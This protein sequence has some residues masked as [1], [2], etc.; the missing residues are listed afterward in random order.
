MELLLHSDL[1]NIPVGDLLSMYFKEAAKEPLLKR[2]EEI[3]LSKQIERGRMARVNL[4]T[5][6]F[7]PDELTSLREMI[8]LENQA[9]DRLIR[10]NTRLVIKV[11]KRY[12]GYG[13]PFIDLIQEGNIG[14]MRAA[15]KYDYTLGHKF[16]TYA[17]WWIRQAVTRAISNQARTIRLPVHWEGEINKFKQTQHSLMQN[18]G[19]KPTLEEM[20]DE[21]HLPLFRVIE[22]QQSTRAPVSLDLAVNEDEDTTLGE[23]ISDD[24]SVA[25]DE[26]ALENLRNEQLMEILD[27]LPTRERNTIEMRF[28]LLDGKTYTLEEVGRQ[29]GVTRERARQ[30]EGQALR[31]LRSTPVKQRLHQF[32]S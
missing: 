27:E 12:L 2:E 4:A 16:S 9:T 26:E 5:G 7:N 32:N 17:T 19:R 21:L 14:L 30:I 18:L 20:A 22:L 13:F 3:E 29:L 25:P 31:R 1:E 15:K 6:N 8:A 10:A 11:A 23:L 24:S 28:G